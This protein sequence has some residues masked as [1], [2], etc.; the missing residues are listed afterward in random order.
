MRSTLY[1]LLIACA[2]VGGCATPYQR[3]GTLGG[4]DDKQLPNGDYIVTVK[5]NGYT[6]RATALEYMHRRAGELCPGGYDLID[7]TDGDNGGVVVSRGHVSQT[8]KPEVDG[9][10]R[11]KDSAQD[12]AREA[13]AYERAHRA[14]LA[15]SRQ[16]NVP[17]PAVE[18]RGFFC[19]SS[20]TNAAV[21]FCVR[22]KTD[23]ERAR[24]VTI[25][26]LPDLA[27]C[28]LVEAAW[29]T[30]DLC[31]PSEEACDARRERT[32][33]ELACVERE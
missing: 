26:S 8:R 17:A 15:Q 14:E 31:F 1:G 9:V 4:Y 19:S 5:V 33:I 20:P 7:R 22:N 13:K 24:D 27:A 21:G 18:P 10:V 12:A 28:A 6:D 16:Q 2:A 11:C 30:E 32:G 25:G 29:C 23:C 3:M